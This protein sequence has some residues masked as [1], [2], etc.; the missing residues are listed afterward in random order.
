MYT[1][2]NTLLISAIT[3]VILLVLIPIVLN[4]PAEAKI[5]PMQSTL[6][7][8]KV[9]IQ[10]IPDQLR[11]TKELDKYELA[12]TETSLTIIEANLIN[13]EKTDSDRNIFISIGSLV[14]I[15]ILLLLPYKKQL[16]N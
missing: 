5:A 11:E 7:I 2:I 12:S 4:P 9:E 15:G 6:E 8:E 3:V 16:I 10:S 14:L 1:K 13:Q